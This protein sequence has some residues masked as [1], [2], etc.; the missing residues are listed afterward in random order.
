[1]YTHEEEPMTDTADPAVEA[2]I[3]L[4]HYIEC[5]KGAGIAEKTLSITRRMGNESKMSETE[6][7]TLLWQAMD[8]L[9]AAGNDLAE[10]TARATEYQRAQ[11]RRQRLVASIAAPPP[12]PGE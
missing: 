7:E 12:E 1:V 3:A 8:L 9:E 2:A 6:A 5:A 10:K 11:I 4:G